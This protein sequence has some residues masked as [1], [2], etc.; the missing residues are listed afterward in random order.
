[1]KWHNC[2]EKHL[3]LCPHADHLIT[4]PR[5][6]NLH[7]NT[8]SFKSVTYFSIKTKPWLRNPD[9]SFIMLLQFRLF[10]KICKAV[11]LHWK[12]LLDKQNVYYENSWRQCVESILQK[13]SETRAQRC[14]TIVVSKLFSSILFRKIPVKWWLIYYCNWPFLHIRWVWNSSS[15]YVEHKTKNERVY[16]HR[17]MGQFNEKTFS[18]NAFLFLQ[19]IR[20]PSF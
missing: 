18:L 7:M 20:P 16:I 11:F 2:V 4:N 5:Q 1:M 17:S 19:F 13:H 9:Y 14:V 10:L 12:M 8:V 3:F 6:I 15:F